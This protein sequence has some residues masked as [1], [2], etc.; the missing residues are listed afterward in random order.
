MKLITF[1]SVFLTVTACA[2]TP[3]ALNA[4]FV[5]GSYE[6]RS[7]NQQSYK[8]VQLRSFDGQ[9]IGSFLQTTQMESVVVPNLSEG[10]FDRAMDL[11]DARFDTD[12]GR[13]ACYQRVIDAT[14]DQCELS[15]VEAECETN[16][17]YDPSVCDD[18]PRQ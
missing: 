10:D 14:I 1:L 17:W 8:F 15:F 6:D 12:S 2:V 11:C 5:E 13:T 9:R 3:E 7:G 4:T 16:C 18:L